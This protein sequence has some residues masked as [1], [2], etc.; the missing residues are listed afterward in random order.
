MAFKKN[1]QHIVVIRERQSMLTL[2][3]VLE[4]KKAEV[5]LAVL[6]QLLK[7][8]PPNAKL[9]ITF[10]NRTEFAQHDQLG[11]PTAFCDPYASWQKGGVENSNGRLRGDLPRYLDIKK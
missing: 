8:I 2:S 11:L 4:N 6:S 1:A 3:A 5:T 7:K 9:S 10:D